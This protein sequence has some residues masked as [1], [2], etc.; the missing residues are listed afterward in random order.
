MNRTPWRMLIAVAI[1]LSIPMYAYA[2]TLTTL[3]S[4]GGS[5]GS[6]PNATPIIVGGQLYGTT[7]FGGAA[8]LGTVYKI[9]P[10]TGAETVLHSFAGGSDGGGGTVFKLTP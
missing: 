5:A 2:A 10:T 7:S 3:F 1:S 6:Y 4:F 8:G 9:D